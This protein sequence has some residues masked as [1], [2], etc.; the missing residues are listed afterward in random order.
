MRRDEE[1]G[2]RGRRKGG[3][4]KKGRKEGRKQGR[5]EVGRER[6]DIG[7]YERNMLQ[8]LIAKLPVPH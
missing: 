2:R 5:K 4:R 8:M 1:R 3:K 6:R 7:K